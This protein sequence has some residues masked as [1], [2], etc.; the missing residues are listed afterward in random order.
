MVLSVAHPDSYTA[1]A[2]L[3]VGGKLQKITVP[4]RDPKDNEVIVKV[5]ACGVCGSDAVIPD[6]LYPTAWPRIPGHEIVGDIVALP[7]SEKVW[8]LGQRVG[9]GWHGGHC[10]TCSRCRLGDFITCPSE[11]I[12]GVSR[13]GG[14]AEYAILRSEA[15]VQIPDGMDP[16]Q[17]GPLLCAGITVY[18][19]LRHMNA[20]P[21]DYVAVQ[22][23]GGL[24]HL[25]LQVAN[26]MGFR[27]VALSSG[28][29]KEAMAR[30]LGAQEYIDGS[31]VDQAEALKA[32]GGAKVIICTAPNSK[33]M[34]S[35]IGGLA[36]DGTLLFIALATEPITISPVSLIGGRLSIRGWP[37]G[38]ATDTEACL[39]FAKAHN[40]KCLVE[41]FPLEKAQEAYDHRAS[42]RFRAVLVPGL[43][44]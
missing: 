42:A 41:T 13:D 17:A 19:S 43:Q 18:N 10:Q 44:N 14:Y 2:F 1:Y 12:N 15:V 22:G 7:E 6:G 20:I 5:L 39:V 27:A 29:G 28:S 24:G 25:A 11:D 32:L 40:I 16:I 34:Q 26:A 36:V 4:W 33:I 21:P 30:E 31:K 3:E 35:L 37:S 38:H 8:K 23:I 9:G